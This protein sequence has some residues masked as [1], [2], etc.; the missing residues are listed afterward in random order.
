MQGKNCG[1]DKNNWLKNKNKRTKQTLGNANPVTQSYKYVK[2][3]TK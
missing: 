2:A 1:K 3:G